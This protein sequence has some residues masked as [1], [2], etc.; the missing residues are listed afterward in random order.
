MARYLFEIGVA[1]QAFAALVKEPQDRE[2]ANRQLFEAAGGTL[3]AYYFAV[4]RSTFYLVA[5]LPDTV[6][7]AALTM[8]ILASG[9]LTSVQSTAILT[10]PEAVEAMQKA[11]TLG[12]RPPS[13]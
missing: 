1:P 13:S 3:E 4:S 5:Q 10:A 11:G 2:Q 12:Y 6:S 9:A 8:A 7:V